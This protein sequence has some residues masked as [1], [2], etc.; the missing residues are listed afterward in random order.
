MKSF[1]KAF[2]ILLTKPFW[3][4]MTGLYQTI[5]LRKF[6]RKSALTPAKEGG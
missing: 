2:L 4:S 3:C 5:Q 1:L 6:V